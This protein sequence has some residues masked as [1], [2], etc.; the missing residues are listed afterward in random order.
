MGTG[1]LCAVAWGWR[2]LM[3]CGHPPLLGSTEMTPLTAQSLLL[4]SLWSGNFP[5]Q[6]Q[7]L[8]H[9]PFP[10]QPP[11]LPKRIPGALGYRPF[12]LEPQSVS[13]APCPG[14]SL[15][16]LCEA[17]SLLG[18]TQSSRPGSSLIWDPYPLPG[19]DSASLLL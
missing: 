6:L 1:G 12:H 8:S 10:P 19:T 16:V 15:A 14:P 18:H 17:L 3:H 11:R 7:F 9:L 13:T 4:R 2:P 5:A